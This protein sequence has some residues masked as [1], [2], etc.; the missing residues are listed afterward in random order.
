MLIKR[1]WF[2]L[3]SKAICSLRMSRV[4][5]SLVMGCLVLTLGMLWGLARQA[6]GL[7]EV[8]PTHAAVT[9]F[10]LM[11]ANYASN[12]MDDSAGQERVSARAP[13]SFT[14]AFTL[15]LPIIFKPIANLKSLVT[16]STVTLPHPL[17]DAS[18]SWCTWGWCSISPRLYQEPIGDGRTFIGWTDSSGDGHVSILSTT[19]SLTQT[20]DFSAQVLRGLT[21]HDD[22]SFAVLLW[23]PNAKR[24]WLSSRNANGTEIWK[25]DITGSLTVFDPGIG[26]S[27]LAY[28]NN[29]Y[30]AY[31]AVYGI[32]G[33]V[34]GHNGDQL[35]Y[36]SS[37][38]SP[39]S[40]GWDWGC[41]HSMA[42]LINYHPALNKFL[43]ICSSDCY[44]SK[45]ILLNDSQVVYA[46]DGN[47]G[48]NVS[49]QL[50][51]A[52]QSDSSWKLVF[53]AMSQPCC[54]GR[55]IGLATI[56]GTNQS[57][58]LWLTDT[59][60]A[61]ER[62]PVIARLGSTLQTDRY[63]VG[64]TTTND[65]VYWLAVITG[66]GTY[67]MGPEEVSS[68]GVAWGNRDDSFRTRADGSVSWVQ[69]DPG[70]T[71]LHFF[72]FDGSAYLP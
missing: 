4:W 61:N 3:N 25:T 66:S 52:A 15:Y 56:N 16:E 57:S 19:G 10:S 29:L 54:D 20:F 59:S 23:D 55:G 69:G 11:P 39:Q 43:P 50:G 68:S 62:D 65:G 32:S 67:L 35:T 53:N 42:E 63:V 7:P 34:Q 44:D 48:G 70:S 9:Q 13:I 46:S 64:W 2:Q 31:F 71:T 30:A 26:D 27:R 37:S 60:G 36:V 21:V 6:A 49:A 24:M 45:G 40:G 33:W 58:Y 5:R 14:A 28:G 8:P 12:F 51:Q 72:H 17:A 47:C 18:F 38:G 41:S 22:G 1:D